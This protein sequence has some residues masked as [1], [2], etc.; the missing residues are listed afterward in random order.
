MRR[1][2][3]VRVFGVGLASLALVA[4]GLT[5]VTSLGRSRR[6]GWGRG[7]SRSGSP[8]RRRRVRRRRLLAGVG[9]WDAGAGGLFGI[10][11]GVRR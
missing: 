11:E 2:I 10:R 3:G 6:R 4:A 9:W 5:S 7:C 1:G 8:R